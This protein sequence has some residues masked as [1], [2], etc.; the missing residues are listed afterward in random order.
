M[1]DTRTPGQVAYAAWHAIVIP[2]LVPG[3]GE[4]WS[5]VS[6]L[7][8]RAWEAAAQA[9]RL[10][11]LADLAWARQAPSS[12]WQVVPQAEEETP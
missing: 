12:R 6:A 9:V 4:D 11:L 7:E 3:Y 8:Q 10:D 5:Q 1:A 2:A